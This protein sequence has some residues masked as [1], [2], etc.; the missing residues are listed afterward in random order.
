M[1]PCAEDGLHIRRPLRRAVLRRSGGERGDKP[2][3][4]HDIGQRVCAVNHLARLALQLL[5]WQ[6]QRRP[7]KPSSWAFMPTATASRTKNSSSSMVGTM[8]VGERPCRAAKR[9]APGGRQAHLIGDGAGAHV[10]RT[11]EDAREDE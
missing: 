7:D 9:P 4:H 10:Q 6:G 3:A 5:A 2:L 1:M 11:A 8:C